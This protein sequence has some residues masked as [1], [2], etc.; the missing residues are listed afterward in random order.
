MQGKTFI[1]DLGRSVDIPDIPQRIVSLAPSITEILFH[2]GLGDRIVGVDRSSNWPAEANEIPRVGDAFRTDMERLKTLRPDAIFTWGSG[3]SIDKLQRV[4]SGGFAV[5]AMEPDGLSD[6]AQLMRRLADI[7]GIRSRGEQR[8]LEFEQAIAHLT[9]SKQSS[10]APIVSTFIQIWHKPLITLSGN[11][12]LSDVIQLCGGRNIFPEPVAN[13]APH[14]GLE[15]V[16]ARQPALILIPGTAD[17]LPAAK[18]FWERWSS[19][20]AVANDQLVTIT[21]EHL[22]RW[23]PRILQGAEELCGIIRNVNDSAMSHVH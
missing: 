22:L 7:H 21:G 20:P 16:I 23:G 3:Y 10:P 15:T 11:H 14:V 19:V 4:A 8:A 6:I 1:D 17:D 9:A 5:F 18:E 13:K 2:L 12:M